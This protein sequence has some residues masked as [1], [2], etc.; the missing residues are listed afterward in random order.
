MFLVE[1]ISLRD[2]ADNAHFGQ[3]VYYYML[4]HT[5][6]FMNINLWYLGMH[7][8]EQKGLCS[9]LLKYMKNANCEYDCYID[10]I[11]VKH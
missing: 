4:V 7:H 8:M 11:I 9:I 2:W 1:L 3:N 6:Y 10:N 5:Y